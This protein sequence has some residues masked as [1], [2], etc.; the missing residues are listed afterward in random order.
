MYTPYGNQYQRPST[1]LPVMQQNYGYQP[2]QTQQPYSLPTVHAEII[3]IRSKQEAESFGVAPGS[4]QMFILNDE[5]GIFIKTAYPNG[6]YE[7]V[8]YFKTEPVQEEQPDYVTKKEFSERIAEL[9]KKIKTEPASVTR[10]REETKGADV[11]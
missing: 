1:Q 3:Q 5:S 9:E 7:L 8:Q 4:S 2:L 6:S 11:K 10:K